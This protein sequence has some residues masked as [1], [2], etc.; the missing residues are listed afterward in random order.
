MHTTLFA[1]IMAG[2]AAGAGKLDY[3][4][5][6][7]VDFRKSDFGPLGPPSAYTIGIAHSGDALTMQIRQSAAFYSYFA[8]VP[9]RTD[10]TV[11]QYRVNGMTM[12]GKAAWDGDSIVTE[13]VS[14]T[15]DRMRNRMTLSTDGKTLTCRVSAASAIGA[16]ELVYV[17]AKE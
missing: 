5:N 6:W 15:G 17:F 10:G 16:L 2:S 8:D 1:A 9:Y 12:K 4:G 14:E 7:K 3:S 13:S 11:T